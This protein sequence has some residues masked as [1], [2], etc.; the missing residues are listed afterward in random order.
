MT[1]ENRL[2]LFGGITAV[3]ALVLGLTLVF[4][5]RQNQVT[6]FT[7]QV[8]AETYTV[9][10]DHAG[11]VV[12]QRVEEGDEVTRGQELFAVQSL[13]LKQDLA[14][15]LEVGD[16]EVYEVQE[17][18]GTITYFSA[19]D[20]RVDSLDARQGNSV[21]AGG[22]LAELTGGDR[23]ITA[24]F[25]LVP[26]DYARVTVG[27]P[28][29]IVLP[30]DEVIVGAVEKVS[31]SSGPDGAVST[32]RISVPALQGVDQQTLAEPGTPVTVAVQ[33]ADTSWFAPV[34]DAVN[35]LLLQIGLR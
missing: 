26:R 30:D 7:A 25:Q 15:G 14:N 2:R 21:P 8:A 31:V 28:A 35:D 29:R 17:S 9:G 22:A 6:S 33:L 4:N 18:T 5:Y 10:A 12:S 3:V 23:Y 27:A 19:I 13:Q 20:G 32:L 11:T 24:S 1:W 16:T 34:T